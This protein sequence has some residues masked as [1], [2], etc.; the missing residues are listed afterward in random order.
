VALRES[1]EQG[2]VRQEKEGKP[3]FV[4]VNDRV[5]LAPVDAHPARRGGVES[6][7]PFRWIVPVKE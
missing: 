6:D 7:D 2:G 1:L 3:R 4:V 5:S